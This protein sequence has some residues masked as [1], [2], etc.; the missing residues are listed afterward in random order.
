M[1]LAYITLMGKRTRARIS[2]AD[3]MVFLDEGLEKL[4][5][6]MSLSELAHSRGVWP[7]TVCKS[8]LRHRRAEYKEALYAGRRQQLAALGGNPARY[9]ALLAHA[10][11]TWPDAFQWPYRKPKEE[12]GIPRKK[13]KR[14]LATGDIPLDLRKV[15]KTGQ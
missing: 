3:L 13:R 12:W 6:G 5:A 4:R 10:V 9:R 2:H 15:S 1:R 11:S 14:A 8:M 7:G